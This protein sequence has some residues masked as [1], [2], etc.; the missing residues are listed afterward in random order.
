[1]LSRFHGVPLIAAVF[2][3]AMLL[4]TTH[5]APALAAGKNKR[6]KTPDVPRP[7]SDYP[8]TLQP[9]TE[10]PQAWEGSP[11]PQP[12]SPQGWQAVPRPQRPMPSTQFHEHLSAPWMYPGYSNMFV[13]GGPMTS[14]PMPNRGETPNRYQPYPP[15]YLRGPFAPLPFP[16]ANPEAA[17]DHGTIEVFLPVAN[18]DVYLNGQKMKGTGK[19]RTF[20][21]GLLQPNQVYQYYVTAKYSQNG[22]PYTDYR[23]VVVGPGEYNVADFTRPPSANPI[24]LPS[25]PVNQNEVAPYTGPHYY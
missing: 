13:P 11:N 14:F 9:S 22:E 20:T 8:G 15:S 7:E 17:P 21:T 12:A 19:D 4:A 3:L 18:A 1:M 2:G 23:K 25:G 24:R 16:N 6:K 10:A 5:P